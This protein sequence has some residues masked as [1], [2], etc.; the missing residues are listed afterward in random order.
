MK[1]YPTIEEILVPPDRTPDAPFNL[2]LGLFFRK[3]KIMTTFWYG[4]YINNVIMSKVSVYY[5]LL[6]SE[7]GL[8]PKY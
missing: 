7:E 4:N 1:F 5:V 3:K 2:Q 8:V 6:I